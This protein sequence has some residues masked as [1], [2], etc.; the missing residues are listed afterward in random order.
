MHDTY[1]IREV[2][3]ELGISRKWAYDLINSRQLFAEKQQGHWRIPK[4]EVRKRKKRLRAI[5][6]L[7][8]AAVSATTKGKSTHKQ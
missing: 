3:V 8:Q 5:E 4:A 1:G 7:R 6:R 2:A